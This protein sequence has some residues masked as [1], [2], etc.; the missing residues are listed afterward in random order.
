MAA[1]P[2]HQPI[3]DA[4][5]PQKMRNLNWLYKFL[6]DLWQRTG[7]QQSGV[8]DLDGLEA[9]VPEINTLVG[10][11]RG[12]TVQQQ[13]NKK[14]DSANLGTMAFQNANGVAISGGTIVGV[15]ISGSTITIPVG[16][17][18]QN[19][20]T[21]GVLHADTT[22]VGNVGTGEDT[23]IT[24]TMPAN[25]LNGNLQFLEIRAFGTVAANANNKEIK[26]KFGTTT[27][28]ATGAVAANSGSWEITA[29][30]IRTGASS[31]KAITK[32]IS[33]N[34]LI[35]DDSS[36]TTPTENTASSIVIQCTGEGTSNNDIVQEGLIIKWFS[37]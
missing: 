30:V 14:E 34:T 4:P 6:H 13:L 37:S 10:I 9:S 21:G 17:S 18:T 29:T 19:A 8:T 22:A 3:I 11:N 26:L 27:L 28:I 15:S 33:N 35:L 12:E 24:Y 5:D 25:A 32:I 2:V 23:L 36:Y 31:Q 1:P 20:T 7:G 16:G